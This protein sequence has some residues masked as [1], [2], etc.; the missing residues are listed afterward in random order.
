M[1]H[2]QVRNRGL[3]KANNVSVWVLY[4]NAGAG[5]PAL[6]LTSSG[7]NSFQF[8]SQFIVTGQILPSLLSD[9]PW[10]AAGPRRILN[11]ITPSKPQVASQSWT[12]PTLG[13][14]NPGHYCPAEFVHCFGSPINETRFDLDDITPTN[15]QIG[16]KNLHAG[17][18]LSSGGDGGSGNGGGGGSPQSGRPMQEYIEFHNSTSS[19]RTA[20]L[21]IDFLRGLPSQLCRLFHPHPA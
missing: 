1:V 20:T 5:L 2:V 18:P 15:K 10:T 21:V 19:I 16:Q 17:S 7:G 14:G 12:V 9:S 4:S 11:G 6:N 8:W 13:S 3:S